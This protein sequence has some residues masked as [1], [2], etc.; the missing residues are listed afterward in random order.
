MVAF[1]LKIRP[2]FSINIITI[3]I[4]L[5]T[6]RQLTI[7]YSQKKVVNMLINTDI[8]KYFCWLSIL[9]LMLVIHKNEINPSK[10]IAFKMIFFFKTMNT[11]IL[12]SSSLIFS[13]EQLIKWIFARNC[14]NYLLKTISV[15]TGYQNYTRIFLLWE[16]WVFKI[17]RVQV[18]FNVKLISYFMR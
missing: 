7:F 16:K 10:F 13:W 12:G 18:K 11:I 15:K 3:D 1:P 8:T 5:Y 2:N 14:K 17:F 6:I 9:C 4:H